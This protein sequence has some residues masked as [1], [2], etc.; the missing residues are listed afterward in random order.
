MKVVKLAIEYGRNEKPFRPYS[1]ANFTNLGT[2]QGDIRPWINRSNSS[3][4]VMALSLTFPTY[5]NS[6]SQGSLISKQMT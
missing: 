6:S 4:S 5:N 2:I 3:V 1:M